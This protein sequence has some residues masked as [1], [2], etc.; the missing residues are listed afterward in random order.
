MSLYNRKP[1][2][3]P[4]VNTKFRKIKTAL[5]VPESIEIIE[6]MEK[7]EPISMSGSHQ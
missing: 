5:P 4:K 3:V 2:V 7:F 6:R 1:I